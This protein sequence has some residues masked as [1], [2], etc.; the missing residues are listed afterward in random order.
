[1]RENPKETI[2]ELALHEPQV[3]AAMKFYTENGLSWTEMLER[4]VLMLVEWRFELWTFKGDKI[5]LYRRPKHGSWFL[6]NAS[7]QAGTDS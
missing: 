6:I 2:I 3:S 4:L 1:M 7:V 5:T